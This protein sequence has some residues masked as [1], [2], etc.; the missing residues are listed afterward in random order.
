MWSF[1][2]NG[3][4]GM[5]LT[6]TGSLVGRVLLY[7]GFGLVTFTGFQLTIDAILSQVKGAMGGMPSEVVS[8]LA[9]LWVDK[10]ISMVFSAF[11]I[12]LSIKLGTG[13][14]IKKWIVTRP[15]I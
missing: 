9:F 7:L 5:L 12:A 3:I 10:A 13:M 1:L 2:I 4:G 15:T 6:L 8:F 11:T 14:A